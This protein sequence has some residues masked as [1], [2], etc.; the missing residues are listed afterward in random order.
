[1]TAAPCFDIIG[2]MKTTVFSMVLAGALAAA[3]GDGKPSR[4]YDIRDFGALGGDRL[5]TEAIQKAVD[6]AW[7]AGG[8]EVVVPEG[9]FRTGGIRL[10]SNVTL[11][12]LEGAVIE[13]SWNYEDYDILDRDR[14]EP[15]GDLPTNG[16]SR[17]TMVTSR[18]SRALIRAY[19]AHNV[20]IIG[21][22]HSLIDGQNCYDAQGEEKYRGP[23][24]VSFW[25]CTGVTLRGYTIRNSA[26]WAHIVVRCPDTRF[27]NIVVP[28]GHD[29]LDIHC[30]TGTVIRACQFYTGDDAIAGFGNVRTRVSDC[31]FCCSCNDVRFGGRDALFERCRSIRPA[32]WGH[33]YR[34]PDEDKACSR[35]HGE[36]ARHDGNLFTYYCDKRWGTIPEP[37]NIVFRD[38][39]FDG[40]TSPCVVDW[41]NRWGNFLPLEDVS[42]ENCRFTNLRQGFK[43]NAC[44]EKP[45]TISVRGCFF[46]AAPEAQGTP[47]VEGAHYKFAGLDE[48]RVKGFKLK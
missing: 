3:A 35:N 7:R 18:W 1:M 29:G 36:A 40:V 22:R 12:L 48:S 11:H 28:G 15:V 16:L 31:V 8:G 13:G 25:D 33:R 45:I 47:F 37:G 34:L 43:V 20:A 24:A 5:D 44:P 30:C 46:E 4:T 26:N 17:S 19:K 32:P 42:F 6:T 10:R 23:H 9:F 14:L 38:C 21:E 41:G 2:N 27:E 39:Q